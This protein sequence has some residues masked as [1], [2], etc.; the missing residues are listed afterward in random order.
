MNR[1][2]KNILF[3][4][5]LLCIAVRAFPALPVKAFGAV[6][7]QTVSG[8]TPNP[9]EE[10]DSKKEL[11]GIR[12]YNLLTA[13]FILP[14]GGEALLAHNI[15]RLETRFRFV[16]A[17]NDQGDIAGLYTESID[18][19][20]V[21]PY[22]TGS[23]TI[24]VTMQLEDDSQDKYFVSD[25]V[26]I[27]KVPV[28]IS[29]PGLFEIW[30]NLVDEDYFNITWLKMLENPFTIQYICSEQPLAPEEMSDWEW[31]D[32]PEDTAFAGSL[33]MRI[34][35]SRLTPNANYYFRILSDA[36]ISSVL[37]V[38]DDGTS[39]ICENINGHRDGSNTDGV[40]L[41][42]VSQPAP[43]LP[44]E[45]NSQEEGSSSETSPAEADTE[46]PSAPPPGDAGAN[47]PSHPGQ[48]DTEAN[49]PSQ[50][51]PE[52]TGSSVPAQP[53]DGSLKPQDETPR[54]TESVTS[55]ED[56]LS[57]DRVLLLLEENGCVRFSKQGIVLTL[58][59]LSLEGLGI[60]SGDSLRIRIDQQ[61]PDLFCFSLWL[62]DIPVTQLDHMEIMLP[63]QAPDDGKKLILV[64]SDEESIAA[65]SYN[66]AQQVVSFELQRAGS[67]RLEQ[68]PASLTEESVLQTDTSSGAP[69]THSV[70]AAAGT[71]VI[72]RF[73]PALWL[74][75][76]LII[77]LLLLFAAYRRRRKPS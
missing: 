36:E 41:P 55:T 61:S 75:V 76:P 39:Y 34:S 44:E 12:N 20:Q 30:V 59:A 2:K 18:S 68:S 3:L 69:D 1:T 15:K 48:K 22:Q 38:V 56:I 71:G 7:D 65:G 70:S 24:T 67:Y 25:N 46:D 60:S 72:L 66:S 8:N 77:A 42:D 45:G 6:R 47:D 58:P 54:H 9:S 14:T 57:G 62:N 51:S 10:P 73:L 43:V 28:R 16:S 11:T 27:L 40:E 5:C 31:E 35:R 52:D 32:C 49:A 21:N 26:R 13:G 50:P 4:I 23:Y 33:K 19:S 17:Y 63:C 74:L 53:A 64:D 29:D 37:H